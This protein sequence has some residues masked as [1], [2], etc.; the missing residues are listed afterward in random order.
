MEHM[1]VDVAIIGAGKSDQTWDGLPGI[2]SCLLTRA[3]NGRAGL[4]GIVFARFY[5][6]TH[7]E[8]RL[9]ILEKDSCIGG[10]WSRGAYST[11]PH[12]YIHL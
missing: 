5:L 11:L 9:A 12:P 1:D 2:P 4:S 10:V 8:C 3:H 7:P 6:D